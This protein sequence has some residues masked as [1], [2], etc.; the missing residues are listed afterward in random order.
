MLRHFVFLFI[1]YKLTEKLNAIP[2]AE[3]SVQ[4]IG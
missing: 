2:L 4:F 1:V 3:A